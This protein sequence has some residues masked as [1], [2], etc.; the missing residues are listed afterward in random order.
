MRS[1]IS[2]RLSVKGHQPGPGARRPLPVPSSG[3]RSTPGGRVV[4]PGSPGEKGI[5]TPPKGVRRD[6][7]P[8]RRKAEEGCPGRGWVRSNEDSFVTRGVLFLSRWS[9]EEGPRKLL[10]LRGRPSP[11][12]RLPH[13]PAEAAGP[14]RTGGRTP[15]LEGQPSPGRTRSPSG[16]RELP[17]LA[18]AASLGASLTSPGL[19]V[20]PAA[21]GEGPW[22]PALGHHLPPSCFH[23]RSTAPAWE[24]AS[25]RA[26]LPKGPGVSSGRGIT[27]GNGGPDGSPWAQENPFRLEPLSLPVHPVGGERSPGRGA[28]AAR[29]SREEGKAE[30]RLLV[31]IVIFHQSPAIC[32]SAPD[33]TPAVLL[34]GVTETTQRWRRANCIC[35]PAHRSKLRPSHGAGKGAKG[36]CDMREI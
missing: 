24:S 16:R 28:A 22:S 9:G 27:A 4:F 7:A 10:R 36:P 33:R 6:A 17:H 32:V 14:G 12:P 26:A 20:C 1:S 21:P 11:P 29:W 25:S 23:P 31:R 8:R 3:H 30:A 19:S 15:G 18:P 13:G 2:R 35:S 5:P 34:A